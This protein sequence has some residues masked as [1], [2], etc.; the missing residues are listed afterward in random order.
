MHHSTLLTAVEREAQACGA[1]LVMVVCAQRDQAKRALLRAA[2]LSVASEW[3]VRL[4]EEPRGR[5]VA[6][7]LREAGV[8][9]VAPLLS[10]SQ[11]AQRPGHSRRQAA[12]PSPR[13]VVQHATATK[14]ATEGAMGRRAPQCG[15]A[16][17]VLRLTPRGADSPQRRLCSYAWLRT[18]RPP[19]TGDVRQICSTKST[20]KRG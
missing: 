7:P 13:L 16:C 5:E 4:L 6:R 14:A 12:S 18:C 2:G 9:S 11:V 15:V 3:Y 17:Q 20:E 8:S 10:A 1:V 19:L